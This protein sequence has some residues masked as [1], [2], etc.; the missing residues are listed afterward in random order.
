MKKIQLNINFWIKELI[1][2]IKMTNVFLR[3]TYWLLFLMMVVVTIDSKLS[4][5]K[6]HSTT[7]TT[8]SISTS[9]SMNSDSFYHRN[10]HHTAGSG[11]CPLSIAL[12]IIIP[13]VGFLFIVTII[14]TVV[15]CV[16]CRDKASRWWTNS[17]Y[18][19]RKCK[20]WRSKSE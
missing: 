4:K 18:Y 17:F 19:I 3:C 16:W 20:C 12:W 1:Y 15:T 5:K 14:A 11:T 6:T 2:K 13:I 9:S 10:V 8:T 7:S